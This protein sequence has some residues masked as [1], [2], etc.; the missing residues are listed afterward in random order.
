MRRDC[1]FEFFW[2]MSQWVPSSRRSLGVGSG[3][4]RKFF[5]TFWPE[6]RGPPESFTR[7][8]QRHGRYLKPRGRAD[9]VAILQAL[10]TSDFT[11]LVT[12]LFPKP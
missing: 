2:T 5:P 7:D 4:Q 1:H 3:G 8:S 12:K 11:F 10:E 6:E 9:F